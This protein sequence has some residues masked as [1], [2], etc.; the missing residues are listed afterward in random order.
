MLLDEYPEVELL[1]H[2]VVQFVIW[3]GA[4]YTVFHNSHTILY[5]LQQ[6]MR[7]LIPVAPH[8]DL[9]DFFCSSHAGGVKW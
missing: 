3:W 7:V 4:S 6:Y 9:S 2:M 8:S 5:S 1:D